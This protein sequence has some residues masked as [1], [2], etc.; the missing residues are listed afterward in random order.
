MGCYSALV[1]SFF[2]VRMGYPVL[3]V[4]DSSPRAFG[5]ISFIPPEA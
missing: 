5:G 1:G 4:P 3:L 2:A